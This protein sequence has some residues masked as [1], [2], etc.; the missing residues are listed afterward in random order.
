MEFVTYLS[1]NKIDMLYDQI[2]AR[3]VP[4]TVEGQVG[5]GIFSGH[6]KSD[7]AVR[8]NYFQK[9]EKVIEQLKNV[10]TVFDEDASYICGEMNMHWQ[11]LRITPEATFW[12]GEDANHNCHSKVMLIGS[13]ENVNGNTPSSNH[14]HYSPLAYFLHAYAQELDLKYENQRIKTLHRATHVY[15][16][17]EE[18][19]FNFRHD[20]NW[21]AT[22]YKF[23]AK[24]LHREQH[25][26]TNGSIER[27][28]IASPLYVSIP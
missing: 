23:L 9:L 18:L 4:I 17:I 22:P 7:D 13:T 11:V 8:N 24:V 16:I 26:A 19:S 20:P 25:L 21:S 5:V 28:I 6:L 2:S 1:K 10:G 15:G 14:F 3:R 27:H 12:Y